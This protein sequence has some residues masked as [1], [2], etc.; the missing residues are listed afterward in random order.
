[1]VQTQP[2]SVH[3]EVYSFYPLP[4]EDA[5][6]SLIANRF[7][8]LTTEKNVEDKSQF[9]NTRFFSQGVKVPDHLAENL[10]KL[11]S[12]INPKICNE[13]LKLFSNLFQYNL[14]HLKL[15]DID[16][17]IC[18]TELLNYSV[19]RFRSIELGSSLPNRWDIYKLSLSFSSSC[20][21]LTSLKLDF[22]PD[23]TIL[24]GTIFD[25]FVKFP[26]L[27]FLY[28]NSPSH[29]NNNVFTNHN[30]NSLIKSC[31]AL[32]V[33]HIYFNEVTADIELNSIIFL[34]NISLKSL[35]LFP[36]LNS[37][38]LLESFDCIEHFLYL[39]NLQELDLSV[40]ID[41]SESN[42]IPL[43]NTEVVNHSLKNLIKTHV[44]QFLN[45]GSSHLAMLESLDISGI[46]KLNDNYI[47]NFIDSHKKLIFLGLCMSRSKFCIN[48][49][50][51]STYKALKVY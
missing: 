46:Y 15:P 26:N 47:K 8:E 30:W 34:Q 23:V 17:E 45:I 12:S 20:Q 5:C 31:P 39:R 10:L 36:L 41:P 43:G 49:D 4:L 40:D 51:A 7:L 50:I 32:E 2:R 28:Y 48:G 24:S 11:T 42:N 37:K 38:P 19:Y 27:V 14:K 13:S 22:Y 25:F 18:G 44:N 16:M 3:D 33:L 21:T 9:K 29:S 6:L 35:I 1:M